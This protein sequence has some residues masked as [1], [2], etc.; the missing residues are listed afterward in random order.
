M[1]SEKLNLAGQPG[2]RARRKL[3]YYPTP[4]NV[5]AAL[6][7]FLQLTP[8]KIWECA[9]GTGSMSKVIRLYGHDVIETDIIT[10]NNYLYTQRSCD[11]IITNPPFN[12]A[13]QFIYKAV[14]EC[15]LVAFLLKSQYWHS[16]SRQKL[17]LQYPPTF[18]LPLAWRPDFLEKERGNKGKPTM[19]C[20]WSV[21]IHDEPG[22]Y[23]IPLQR[24]ENYMQISLF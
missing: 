19:E 6:M 21:W 14:Q 1:I 17:F 7:E 8:C 22:V 5:T 15:R 4:P 2:D 16:R 12:L 20:A 11:A 18:V 23:Y 3:D 13:D 10:G 24:P 9:S